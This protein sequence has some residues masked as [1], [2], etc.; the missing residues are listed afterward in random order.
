MNRSPITAQILW[1]YMDGYD[2]HTAN[3]WMGRVFMLREYMSR[4]HFFNCTS[5]P[6][7]VKSDPPPPSN[8]DSL[9]QVVPWLENKIQYLST[10]NMCCRFISLFCLNRNILSHGW[11]EL[12][13]LQEN[14][15]CCLLLFKIR[16]LKSTF[17]IFEQN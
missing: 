14:I 10:C 4:G 3:I 12:T 7:F 11:K 1:Q 15:N 2:F 5:I 16:W 13:F 17:L 8:T 9:L 6:N